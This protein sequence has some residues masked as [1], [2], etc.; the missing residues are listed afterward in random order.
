VTVQPGPS[1]TTAMILGAGRGTRLARLGLGVPKVLVEIGG[2][3]LL[4]SQI[5]YLGREGIERVV[6]NAH[7][8]AK[9]IEAFARNL[10]GPADVTVVTEAKLLG[11]AGGVRNALDILGEDSFFVLYG[12]VVFDCPLAPI[13]EAHRTRR[14]DATLTVYESNTV[15]G[16]GTVVIDEGGWVTGFGEK[17]GPTELPAF[18]NAGLYQLEP[19][20]MADVPLAVESDFGRDVFPAALARGSRVLAYALP[21]PVIDVGT[22][23]DLALARARAATAS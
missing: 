12:D 15:E 19:E 17:R 14:A 22:P 20:F 23:E 3:P 11:T 21:E 8:Q 16:K 13:T 5:E 1:V 9:A 7:H 4:A 10:D 2:R 18:I 6:I